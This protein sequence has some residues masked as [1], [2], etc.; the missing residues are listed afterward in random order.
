MWVEYWVDVLADA[1]DVDSERMLA[2]HSASLKVGHW[3]L[4]SV[5]VKADRL[6][7]VL[8]EHSVDSKVDG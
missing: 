1:S 7:I 3:V 5:D 4:R 2:E 8:A 6:A